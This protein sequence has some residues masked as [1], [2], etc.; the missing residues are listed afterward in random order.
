[1]GFNW[2]LGVF[3]GVG[4][5]ADRVEAVGIACL[6]N[7]TFA[8]NAKAAQPSSPSSNS[9]T[10]RAR[11]R[12]RPP[13]SRITRLASSASS[14]SSAACSPS[15]TARALWTSFAAVTSSFGGAGP[16]GFG[17]PGA[18][19]SVGSDAPGGSEGPEAEVG[20]TRDVTMV[21]CSFSSS[22]VTLLRAPTP[23]PDCAEIR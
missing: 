22:A 11:E 17:R 5:G 20:G 4:E 2:R 19:P 13:A 10:E 8:A 21:R 12:R 18:P 6:Q 1:M 23:I 16:A 14:A 7:R 9:F 3:G 15:C